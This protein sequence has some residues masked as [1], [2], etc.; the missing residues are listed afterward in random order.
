[1]KNFL[2]YLTSLAGVLLLASS[3]SA[4]ASPADQC[5][6]YGGPP[7][8]PPGPSYPIGG[9]KIALPGTPSSPSSPSTPSKPSTPSTPSTPTTPTTPT[10]PATPSTPAGP[11][12]P[13]APASTGGG[14]LPTDHGRTAKTFL[15]MR[16]SYPVHEFFTPERSKAFT[17]AGRYSTALPRTEAFYRVSENDRRPLLVLRECLYCNG[18]DDALLSSTS[19]NE[20]TLI[21][22]RWFH[23]VKMPMDVLHKDHIFRNLFEQEHPPHAFLARWDGSNV[24]AFKGDANQN[25]LWEGMYTMLASE[26]KKDAHKAVKDI[27]LL[28]AQYDMY[29]H[30]ISKL[31]YDY[32]FEVEASGQNSRKAKKIQKRLDELNDD[33]ADLQKAEVKASSLKLKKPKDRPNAHIASQAIPASVSAH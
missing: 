12:A 23:C 11:A 28:I 4:A 29:D 19:G 10:G 14:P 13:G 16:W 27:E 26:Y 22:T 7:P 3:A 15:K 5:G 20:R 24:I 9:G 1:M 31:E 8:P 33:L 21:M 30:K 17:V 2:L 32:E 25:D 6:G 18:T